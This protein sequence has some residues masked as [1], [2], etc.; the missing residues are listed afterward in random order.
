MLLTMPGERK[1][2]IKAALILLQDELDFS[3]HQRTPSDILVTT[4]PSSGQGK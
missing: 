2:C 1:R 3:Y 4:L